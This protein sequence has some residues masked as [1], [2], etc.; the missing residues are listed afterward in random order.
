MVT[1]PGMDAFFKVGN[2]SGSG[3]TGVVAVPGMDALFK[4]GN[5]SGWHVQGRVIE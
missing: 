3:I 4:A 2:L 5:L 1:V